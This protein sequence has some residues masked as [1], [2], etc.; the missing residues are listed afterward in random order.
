[1]KLFFPVSSSQDCL[2]IQSEL[3]RLVQWCDKNALPLNVRKCKIMSFTRSF[4]PVRFA[5]TIGSFTLERVVSFID[6]GVILDNR[7]TLRNYIDAITA[8]ELA[9]VGFIER[10]YD[11]CPE[12]ICPEDIFSEDI[13]LEDISPDK[14]LP[15]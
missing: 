3:D 14:Y 10:F 5:Y 15:G 13:C 2:N 9:M 8:K 11:I 7:L 1:M 12:D 6:L 4:S